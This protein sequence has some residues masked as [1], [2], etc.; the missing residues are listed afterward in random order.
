VGVVRVRVTIMV[1]IFVEL[2]E[3]NDDVL[4]GFNVLNTN[5]L[6]LE[7]VVLGVLV[8][9]DWTMWVSV[10]SSVM[11]LGF[12]FL[13]KILEIVFWTVSA[14][15]VHMI[16]IRVRVGVRVIRVRVVSFWSMV[17]SG[18]ELLESNDDVL[19]RF[20]LVNTNVLGLEQ[21]VFGVLVLL[22]SVEVMWMVWVLNLALKLL[23]TSPT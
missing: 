1:C 6:G 22:D 15:V 17:G 18:V 5:I 7:Q 19:G 4:S 3:S 14:G 11:F 8:L 21:V 9:L 2:L 13:I 12:I 20:N 16:R 10:L 23:E